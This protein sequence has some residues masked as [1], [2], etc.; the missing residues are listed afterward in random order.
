MEKLKRLTNFTTETN[1][2]L[3]KNVIAN[4]MWAFLDHEFDRVKINAKSKEGTRFKGWITR[5]GIYDFMSDQRK[6][7]LNR[8]EKLIQSKG[9][10]LTSKNYE[11]IDKSIVYLENYSGS[12]ADFNLNYIICQKDFVN[13]FARLVGKK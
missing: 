6:K 7:E 1:H 3:Y 13:D 8:I 9:H 11:A 4:C 10:E 12:Y 2:Y 5:K